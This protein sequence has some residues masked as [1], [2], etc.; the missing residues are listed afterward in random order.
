MYGKCKFSI[1]C[2]VVICKN[3]VVSINKVFC[4]NGNCLSLIKDVPVCLGHAKH[5]YCNKCKAKK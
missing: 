3:N 2:S 4:N 1:K 5:V